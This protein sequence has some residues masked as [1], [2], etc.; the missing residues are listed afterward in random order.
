VVPQIGHEGQSRLLRQGGGTLA[1]AAAL[2]LMIRG[3]FDM[4]LLLAGGGA[5]LF[6]WGGLSLPS[7]LGGRQAAGLGAVSRVRTAM[8]E[9]EIDHGSGAM[10]GLVLAGPFLGRALGDLG[11]VELRQLGESCRRDDPDGERLLQAYLDRRF[12]G[13]REHAQ[14]DAHTGPRPNPQSGAMT[15]EEAYEVLGLQP[16]SEAEAVRRA[17]RNLMKKLHPDQ[18]GSTYLASRVNQAKDVLLNRHR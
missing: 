9:M 13:R 5:W 15:Q 1:F 18:G 4:A 3:R 11:P 2:V 10:R 14:R 7:L 17:H 8:I 16:G 12:S 6:G